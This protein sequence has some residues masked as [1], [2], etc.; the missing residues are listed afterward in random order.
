MADN[1][2]GE[3][4]L[5]KGALRDELGVKKGEKIPKTLLQD[6]KKALEAKSKEGDLSKKEL[7]LLRRINLAITFSK[8]KK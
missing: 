3:I 4:G 1:W 8:M 7:R 2:I 6:K 5:K